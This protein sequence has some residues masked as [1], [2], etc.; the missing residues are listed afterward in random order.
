MCNNVDDAVVR[1]APAYLCLLTGENTVQGNLKRCK[2][3]LMMS[4]DA[5]D[6]ERTGLV[7]IYGRKHSTKVINLD[8]HPTNTL[9]GDIFLVLPEAVSAT[10]IVT[11]WL[12][13]M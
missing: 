2:W 3:D 8:H 11:L 13:N 5:S 1:D 9:F 10:E 7:G 4:V 12:A 6:E